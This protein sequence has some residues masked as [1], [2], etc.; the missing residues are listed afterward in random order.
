MAAR[1]DDKVRLRPR[2]QHRRHTS[3]AH[4]DQ[5]LPGSR[6]TGR[7]IRAPKD[8]RSFQN[9]KHR[10]NNTMSRCRRDSGIGGYDRGGDE[11]L[12]RGEP[13]LGIKFS[14]KKGERQ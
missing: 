10:L 11:Q 13:T 6:Q 5:D 3:Q 12:Q 2:R 4:K 1:L 9:E 7:R 8:D 14:G